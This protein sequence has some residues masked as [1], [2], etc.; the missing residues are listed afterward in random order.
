MKKCPNCQKTFDDNMKF[1]QVDGTPLVVVADNQPKEDPYAT[2]VANKSDLQIPPEETKV[3]PKE[4]EDPYKTVVGSPAMPKSEPKKEEDLLEVPGDDEIDP[5]KT[6]VVGRNT[7]DNIR[8]NIP[9]EKPKEEP[10]PS[11]NIASEE[12]EAK[13]MISPEIPK[14]S[15]PNIAPPNLGDPASKSEPKDSPPKPITPPVKSEPVAKTEKPSIE[16]K[17]QTPKADEE[18][19]TPIQSPFDNSM[20]PG[21][22]PPSTPPFEPPKEP[23]KPEPL[24]VPKEETPKSPFAEKETPSSPF[25]DNK[26]KSPN[27]V[28]SK[29]PVSASDT[30]NWQP[31]PAPMKEFEGKE[32]GQN[33]PFETPPAVGGQNQTL[34]IVSLVLGILNVT[35]C[36]GSGLLLGTAALILGFIAR[37]KAKDNPDEYGGEKFALIGMITG[38][39]GI[40]LSIVIIVVQIVFGG[41]ANF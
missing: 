34:A 10:K 6:M 17:P 19:Q 25:A 31:P 20:P 40:V 13:T 5:M 26:P 11:D 36:C 37:G 18:K 21:Y 23:L 14:F 28:D 27:V 1:C 3:E 29:A 9:E 39:L 4:E 24:N 30:D 41:L 8:V 16:S 7:S 38:A 32:I 12:S 15:E 22:A 33:T 2:M 35:I